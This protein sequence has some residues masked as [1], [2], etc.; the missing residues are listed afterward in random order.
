MSWTVEVTG[1]FERW[2]EQLTEEERISIDGMI[3][4]LEAQGLALGEPYASAVAGSAVTHLHQLRVPHAE[5]A[6][7][8][9]YVPDPAVNVVLLLTGTTRGSTETICPPAEIEQAEIIYTEFVISR[10]RPH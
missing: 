1:Q 4:V 6:I 5:R 3:R 10:N 7:C 8:V 9:L 2:W